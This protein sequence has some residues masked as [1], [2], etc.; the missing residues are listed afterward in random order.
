MHEDLHLFTN[1]LVDIVMPLT[2]AFRN[3]DVTLASP[4][5]LGM[6][7]QSRLTLSNL[8]DSVQRNHKKMQS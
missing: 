5:H 1:L 2:C 6:S 4:A 8:S 7:E 3:R